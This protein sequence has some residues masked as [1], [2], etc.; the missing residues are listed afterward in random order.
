VVGTGSQEAE[1]FFLFTFLVQLFFLVCSESFL[2]SS[3]SARIFVYAARVI[4]VGAFFITKVSRFGIPVPTS[5]C[6]GRFTDLYFPF[7][8]QSSYSSNQ[9]KHLVDSIRSFV[10]VASHPCSIVFP[11]RFAPARRHLC[12]LSSARI[13]FSSARNPFPI[14]S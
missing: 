13:W 9:S 6:V 14:L 5:K 4:C 8:F 3:A 10:L 7:D 11:A 12:L 1:S 2:L